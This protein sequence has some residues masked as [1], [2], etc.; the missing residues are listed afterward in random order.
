MDLRGTLGKSATALAAL[1][2]SLGISSCG[3]PW[4]SREL[5]R[6]SPPWIFLGHSPIWAYVEAYG[7]TWSPRQA[8]KGLSGLSAKPQDILPWTSVELTGS[9]EKLPTMDFPRAGPYMGLR[10]A[11]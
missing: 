8:S 10:G 2:L 4:S 5:S 9:L 1:A 7:L 3:T 6:G 11:L